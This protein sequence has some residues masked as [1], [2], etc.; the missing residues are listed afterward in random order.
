MYFCVACHHQKE[1]I[2]N[3]AE[4]AFA[5]MVTAGKEDEDWLY[6]NELSP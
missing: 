2:E 3:S 6:D 1:E 4:G 5:R